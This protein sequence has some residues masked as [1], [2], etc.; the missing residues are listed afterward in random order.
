M[1]QLYSGTPGSGKSLHMAK[2]IYY[3]LI[4]GY[5]CIANFEITM[6]KKTKGEFI[7]KQNDELTPKFLKEY[8]RKH[9]KGK[10][11]KEDKINLMIDECQLI[12]NAREWNKSDRAE[13]LSFFTQHRKLGYK[14][15]LVAQFDAMIDKQIR[16]LIEYNYIHRKVSN[17]GWFGF[18]LSVINL[19]NLF[20]SVKVWYPLRQK[21]GSEF[22]KAKKRYYSIYDTFGI[23]DEEKPSEDTK[24]LK[25]QNTALQEDIRKLPFENDEGAQPIPEELIQEIKELK[26]G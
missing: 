25:N 8:S 7:Y 9:F 2:D 4:F 20:V 24:P 19:G 12:F 1:I 16:S 18:F 10:R 13:W 11:P 14:I 23:L 5:P 26:Q 15:T 17:F 6:K 21:V 22:F 3:S